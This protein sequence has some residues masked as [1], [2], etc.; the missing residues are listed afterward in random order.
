[1]S[2]EMLMKTSRWL[3]VA[4]VVLITALEVVVFAAVTSTARAATP[5]PC[6]LTLRVE[7]TPGVP[8]PGDPGFLSSLLSNH[9]DYRLT[10]ERRDFYHG[11]VV[12][13]DLTGPGPTSSCRRVL[14]SMRRDARV[15]TA[16]VERRSS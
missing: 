16:R 14:A 7:V 6:D 1:M 13:L 3:T 11:S 4:A 15:F 5:A 8:N 10:L 12:F 9:P 2:A